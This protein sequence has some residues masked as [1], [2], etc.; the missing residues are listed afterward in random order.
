MLQP[1]LNIL[2]IIAFQVLIASSFRTLTISKSNLYRPTAS[3]E[4]SMST[5]SKAE[6]QLE[7]I[8][9]MS[10]DPALLDEYESALSTVI[11]FMGPGKKKER[12]IDF[13]P[14]KEYLMSRHA[15]LSKPNVEDESFNRESMVKQQEM[16]LAKTNLSQAQYD[17][18]G[19]VLTYLGHFSAK[20]KKPSF[21]KY[22]ASGSFFCG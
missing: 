16:F 4:K 7:T 2:L 22:C 1:L 14:A 21:R 9:K 12:K 20:T 8:K 11:A 15:V 13:S 18:V 10:F 6:N 3:V 19:R 17:Y 5:S